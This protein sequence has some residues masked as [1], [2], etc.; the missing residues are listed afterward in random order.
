[1]RKASNDLGVSIITCTNKPQFIDNIFANYN[2]Q[3]WK[4]KQL[5]IVLNK[6][7]V[8]LA[9][10]LRRASRYREVS[11][12]R[13]PEQV[14]LGKCLNFA[15]RKTKYPFIA[16][17]DDDDY[18]APRYVSDTMHDFSKTNAD[19][20]GKRTIYTYLEHRHL[21]LL[22]FPNREN[23][24]VRLV[25]GATIFAKR[26]VFQ[27]VPFADVSL[28][29]DLRFLRACNSRGFKIYSSDR[30]NFVVHRRKSPKNH[31]WITTDQYLIRTGKIITST[32][33]SV[34]YAIRPRHRHN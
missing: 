19:V 7:N 30:Y 22:R 10:Y 4:A 23:R 29:E 15:V 5:V 32:S 28:G 24:F 17:F 27:T 34:P 12:Y 9:P 3:I 26:K 20:V 21:L 11:V 31:T 33:H 14:S 6:D 25:S 8:R 16:K 1:M 18:Y 2:R 13:L